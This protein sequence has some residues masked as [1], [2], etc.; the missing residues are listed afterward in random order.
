MKNKTC[1]EV[2]FTRLTVHNRFL[3][4]LF[5]YNFVTVI[6]VIYSCKAHRDVY[7]YYALYKCYLLLLFASLCQLTNYSK[8]KMQFKCF[9]HYTYIRPKCK[10][11]TYCQCS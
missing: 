5:V 9:I 4:Y 10:E 3:K 11:G 6:V 8:D 2:G 1:S 7:S